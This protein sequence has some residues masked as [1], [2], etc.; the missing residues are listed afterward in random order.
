LIKLIKK[1]KCIRLNLE[2]IL[3]MERKN[4]KTNSNAVNIIKIVVKFSIMPNQTKINKTNTP[5]LIC[6]DNQEKSTLL[7]LLYIRK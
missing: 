1:L 3:A 6:S 7:K 5:N 2:L 4:K